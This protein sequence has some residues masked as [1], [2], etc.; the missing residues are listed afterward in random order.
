VKEW[1]LF[2][3]VSAMGMVSRATRLFVFDASYVAE[4]IG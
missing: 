1:M 2:C 3:D 4:T